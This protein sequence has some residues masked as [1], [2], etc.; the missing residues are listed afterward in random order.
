M[1]VLVARPAPEIQ[2]PAAPGRRP[3][4]D[5]SHYVFREPD[6]PGRVSPGRKQGG[7]AARDSTFSQVPR[8]T[9][10]AVTRATAAH[11]ALPHGRPWIKPKLV[12]LTGAHARG[13]RDHPL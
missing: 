2:R 12:R 13:V 4:S 9:T 8:S 1:Q 3:F 5:V 6:G 11:H 7:M 10:L